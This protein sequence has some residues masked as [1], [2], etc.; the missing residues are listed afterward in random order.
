MFPGAGGGQAGGHSRGIPRPEGQQDGPHS[1]LEH[2]LSPEWNGWQTLL[3]L[4]VCMVLQRSQRGTQTLSRAQW[5]RAD[6]ERRGEMLGRG[7]GG[8]VWISTW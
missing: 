4:E 2:P 6:G 8:W 1:Y 3:Q 5:E 7:G